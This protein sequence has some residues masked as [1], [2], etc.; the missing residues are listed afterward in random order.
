MD[1]PLELRVYFYVRFEDKD[2]AK[3]LG[4]RWDPYRKMW[5]SLD[6]NQGLN[7]IDKC[8]ETWP[9]PA[10]FK[11]EENRVPFVKK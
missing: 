1:I 6:S 2:I 8:L 7:K 5:Y 3:S 10:P 9:V 4:C 11:I